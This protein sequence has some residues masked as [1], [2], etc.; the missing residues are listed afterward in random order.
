[1]HILHLEDN[2]ADAEMAEMLLHS[3]WPDCSVTALTSREA[4]EA[5]VRSGDFDLILSDYSLPQY[6]GLDALAYART[7]C[8]EKPFVYLSGTIGEDRAIQALKCGATDYVLKDR[9]A[10]LISAISAA[11]AQI[12]QVDARRRAEERIREQAS[13]LDKAREAIY[14]ADATGNVTYWNASAERLYGWTALEAVGSNL[15]ETI[16]ADDSAR[17]D[18]A[19]ALVLAAGEWRGELCPRP[20][21]SEAILI[22]SFWSLVTDNSGLARS[23]LIIDADITEKRRIENQLQQSQRL[24]TLGL[25]VGGIAHDLNGMLTPILTSLGLLRERAVGSEDFELV[26]ILDTSAHHGADLVRQLLAFARGKGEQRGELAIDALVGSVRRLLQ[27][28]VPSNIEINV[29]LDNALWPVHADATQLRQV[30]LNL[31]LNAR[32]AM[33]QG[34]KI[35][36]RAR[37]IQVESAMISLLGEARPG[38]HVCI[39]VADTGTGIPPEIIAKIFEPFFTT[40]QTSKGTGLGLANVASITKSHGGFLDVESVPDVGSTFHIYLPALVHELANRSAGVAPQLVMQGQGEN[41]L[42]IDD[43]AGIR[44]VLSVVL[45]TRGYRVTV[46][47]NGEEGL[48]LIRARPDKFALVITDL[49]MPGMS[50]IDL[51]QEIRALPSPPKLIVAS[52]R[53]RN[54]GEEFSELA[55]IEF[56]AKPTTVASLLSA[57][58][59]VLVGAPSAPTYIA[60]AVR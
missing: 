58:R 57:V 5:A 11:F 6:S 55:G 3:R 36:I 28:V 25:L 8:P 24:E 37:G 59:R 45:N 1:M 12:E 26:E 2:T 50:G 13:L 21:R 27:P 22:E 42:L 10:R 47:A 60:T 39:S 30:L 56:L 7:H 38:P 18:T 19:Y 48:E 15:R 29:S 32:D 53:P 40:K 23:I 51:I 54:P 44:T 31:C 16:Y 35:Q 4:F 9:P 20:R 34:G 17:F 43:D 46:V 52:G 14:V 49:S 41:I 33:P